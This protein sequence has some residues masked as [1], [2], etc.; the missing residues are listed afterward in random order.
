MLYECDEM[1]IH[2]HHLTD[3]INNGTS[4]GIDQPIENL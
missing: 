1:E 2:R 4:I 3:Y